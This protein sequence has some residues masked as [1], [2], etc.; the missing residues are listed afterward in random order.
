MG[1]DFR[2][3][4]SHL[5]EYIRI[6]KAI[7]HDGAVDVRALANVRIAA[8]VEDAGMQSFNPSPS[9]YAGPRPTERSWVCP[10]PQGC[11]PARHEG[12]SGE[13]RTPVPHGDN[14]RKGVKR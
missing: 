2:A 4:L 14:V 7:L 13:G 6:L 10:V 5:S 9:S 12:G 3:P 8:P 1:A 11:G